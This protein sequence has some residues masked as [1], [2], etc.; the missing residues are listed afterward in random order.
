MNKIK[1]ISPETYFT[2]QNLIPY[3]FNDKFMIEKSR[4]FLFNLDSLRI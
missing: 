4:N 1:S 2:R 3:L